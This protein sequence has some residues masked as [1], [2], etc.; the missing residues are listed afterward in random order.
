MDNNNW[1]IAG[2]WNE[3]DNL[4]RREVK[5]RDH[6][7]A[8]DIGKSMLDRWLKM[9]GTPETNPSDDRVLR[10]FSAGDTFHY[11]LARMFHR[12]GIVID[13][14]KRMEIPAGNGTLKITGYADL[15]LGGKVNIEQVVK[16][17]ENDEFLPPLFKEKGIRIAEYF[18]NKYPDG[19]SPVVAEIKSV[20]SNAFWAK[21]DY[22]SEAYPW[23][24]LQLYAYLKGF[25]MPEGR[26]LYIS[27][28]DLSLVEHNVFY[29]SEKLEKIFNEDVKQISH[30][31]LNNI[32]PER[33]PDM[34]FNKKKGKGGLWEPNWMLARS[35]YL[36]LI[37]GL[38]AE[39]WEKQ[40]RAET[41]EK[42]KEQLKERR[43][44]AKI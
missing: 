34:V 27:K 12:I 44:K 33:E 26:L 14:E 35:P 36:T 2:L 5:E 28:D 4:E 37:T 32:K 13:R 18:A 17:F 19:F 7:Y 3:K 30:Y 41:K 10:I 8:T 42:N 21:K 9:R 31:H 29:P 23:H 40:V 15:V 39:K 16:D 20:N 43:A 6:I 11:L 24:V 38:T 25:N 22:L 1:S